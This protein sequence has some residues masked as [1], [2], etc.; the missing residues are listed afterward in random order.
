MVG[1]NAAVSAVAAPAG[2]AFGFSEQVKEEQKRLDAEAKAGETQAVQGAQEAGIVKPSVPFGNVS[3]NPITGISDN[4]ADTLAKELRKQNAVKAG[5]PSTGDTNTDATI[6][7]TLIGGF[8]LARYRRG[9]GNAVGNAID[10]Y[11]PPLSKKLGGYDP[12][13]PRDANADEPAR[14]HG[15][16]TC[17]RYCINA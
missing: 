8:L 1:A 9:I 11:A 12:S 6:G 2:E 13:D 4:T 5:F 14:T 16:A 10:K 7:A 17:Q 3:S 15:T